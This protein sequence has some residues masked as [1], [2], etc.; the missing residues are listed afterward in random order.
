MKKFGFYLQREGWRS[1]EL[2]YTYFQC[3]LIRTSYISPNVIAY[4]FK[5]IIF[6]HKLHIEFRRPRK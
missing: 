1:P 2:R 3:S 4:I 6:A 5:I